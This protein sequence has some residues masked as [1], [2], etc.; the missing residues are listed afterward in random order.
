MARE[1]LQS[2]TEP[3][4]YVLLSLTLP[5]HGYEIMQVIGE[6]SGGRVK[7]GAGTLYAL[8][9]RF[10]KEKII[11]QVAN[12]GRR[13]IYSLT[14]KGR[15]ILIEEHNR[16]QLQVTDGKKFLEVGYHE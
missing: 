13:K 3:M 16:L 7:V 2:L 1:Q 5:R 6:V 15:E 9:S 10:E 11:T 4:Y 14:P 8:L 12:E